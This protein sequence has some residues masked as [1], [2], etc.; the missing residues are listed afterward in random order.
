[1]DSSLYRWVKECKNGVGTSRGREKGK[2]EGEWV[3]SKYFISMYENRTMKPVEIVLR[4]GSEKERDRGCEF[5][6]GTL[7]ACVEVSQWNHFVQLI[8]AY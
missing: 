7:Y 2:G 1:M 5:D 4:R 3:W 8:Y 6:W